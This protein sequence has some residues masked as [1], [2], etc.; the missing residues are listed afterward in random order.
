M[1]AL[2]VSDCKLDQ[3]KAHEVMCYLYWMERDQ[4]S[5][6]VSSSNHARCARNPRVLSEGPSCDDTDGA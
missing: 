2:D 4:R 3:L 5:E 6:I 1:R